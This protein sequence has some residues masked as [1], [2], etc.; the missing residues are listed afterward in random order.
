MMMEFSPSALKS[1]QARND[2]PTSREISWV[3]PPTLPLTDSRSPRVLVALGSI[4]YSAVTQPRPL[5]RRQ[6]GM[7]SSTLAAHS[8]RVEPNSTSTEPSACS[9]QPLVILTSRSW[10]GRRSSG[11]DMRASVSALR[12]RRSGRR[13]VRGARLDPLAHGP[14]SVGESGL[15]PPAQVAPGP[16]HRQCAPLQLT[17]PGGGQLRF[18]G[19]A[20]HLADHLGQL[21]HADLDAGPDVPGPRPVPVG[22]GQERGHGVSDIDIVASLGAITEDRRADVFKN[23][24]AENWYDAGLAGWVLSRPV[25]IS[26]P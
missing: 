8:T 18:D 14:D 12:Q 10:S 19:L 1:T 21:K 2:R 22:R 5:P 13:P 11:L 17:G 26:Q 20:G 25:D 24:G 9:S 7:S 16:L 4:A 23:L 3:R 15:R 6:R